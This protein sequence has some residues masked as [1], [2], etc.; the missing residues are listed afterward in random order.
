MDEDLCPICLDTIDSNKDSITLKC[1]HKYHK[2]CINRWFKQKQICP[3]CRMPHYE[4]YTAKQVFFPYLKQKIS[5]GDDK[6]FI[7]T[8]FKTVTYDYKRIK[9]I[10]CYKRYMSLEVVNEN[11]NEN[12]NESKLVKFLFKNSEYSNYFFT[13]LKNKL[14]GLV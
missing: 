3:Y 11:E 13:N 10:I 12:E 14:L 9:K 6:L 8:M 4:F 7:K 1:N 5:F 2:K